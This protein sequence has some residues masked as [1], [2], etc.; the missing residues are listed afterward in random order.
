MGSN[1]CRQGRHAESPPG[2]IQH[3]MVGKLRP[4][5][6]HLKDLTG[7]R[8]GGPPPKAELLHNSLLK[9]DRARLLEMV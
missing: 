4:E 2:A 9:P 3:A 5:V 7:V 8:G 6:K 1:A